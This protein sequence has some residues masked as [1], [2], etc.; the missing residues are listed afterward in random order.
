MN[1]LF[2]HYFKIS[3]AGHMKKQ[4]KVIGHFYARDIKG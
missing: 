2:T 4:K 3:K 1:P